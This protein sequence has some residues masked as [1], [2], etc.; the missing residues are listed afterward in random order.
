MFK[1][2]NFNFFN[3]KKN[4][5]KYIIDNDIQSVKNYINSGYDL[6]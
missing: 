4:I 1:F 6:I 3:K 5:F 2:K